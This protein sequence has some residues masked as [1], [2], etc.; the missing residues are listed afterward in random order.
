MQFEQTSDNC[1][2]CVKCGS[3]VGLVRVDLCGEFVVGVKNGEPVST[4]KVNCDAK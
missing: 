2:L 3:V 1:V 4:C